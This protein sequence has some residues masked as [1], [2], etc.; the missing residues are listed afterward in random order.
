[1]ARK[2]KEITYEVVENTALI[3]VRGKILKI[4][5]EDLWILKEFQH[6][7]IG[8]GGYASVSRYVNTEF[9]Q[10]K[11]QYS[12][13]RIIMKRHKLMLKYEE[14][15]HINRNRLDNRK[16]NLRPC[17]RGLNAM[18][19]SKRTGCTSK[20]KG[21]SY[22]LRNKTNPWIA[23]ISLKCK[24]QHLGYFKTPEEAALVYDKN[25][26]EKFKEFAVLNFPD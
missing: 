10:S 2:K 19:R 3:N 7:I 18:N 8:T 14:L 4:D 9:G 16:C 12:V 21:V 26:K 20:Y 1:M 11:E 24:R 15:D 17:N 23:Y 25:A 5:A 6:L 22:S 13:H